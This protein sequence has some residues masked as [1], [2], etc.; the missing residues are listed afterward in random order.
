MPN[1]FNADDI[2]E[3]AVKIEKNGAAFYREAAGK[4]K[5]KEHK[6]FLEE[7]ARM[8]DDHALTFADMKKTLKDDEK[9]FAGFD[10]DEENILY[11]NALADSRV[12]FK[13]EQPGDDFQKILDA[14]IQTEKDSIAFY[15]GMK[16]LVPPKLGQEKLD[17]IIREEMKHIRI[18]SEKLA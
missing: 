2:F 8:E 1:Q 7:L 5:E 4:V 18:L 16:A 17:E 10:P 13:K 11:L 12:F 15:L 9:T 6:D 14:A 3:M